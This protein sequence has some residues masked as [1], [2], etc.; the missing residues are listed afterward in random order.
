MLVYSF[1]TF[2]ALDRF[3][4]VHVDETWYSAYLSSADLPCGECMEAACRFGD[5][6]CLTRYTPEMIFTLA[7]ALL[8]KSKNRGKSPEDVMPQLWVDRPDA[9]L[10][11]FA[12][13]TNNKASGRCF[14]TEV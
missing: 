1:F 5:V 11:E 7:S 12:K 6:H 14:S 8:K 13:L 4:L 10:I 3:P 2:R 9:K